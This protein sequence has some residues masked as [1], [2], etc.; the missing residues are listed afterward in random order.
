MTEKT[1]KNFK[2]LNVQ[3]QLLFLLTV[4]ADDKGEVR[5]NKEEL[6]KYLDVSRQTVGVHLK[7]FATCNLLKYKYSGIAKLN[8]E[9][10]Y[11]GT[12]VNLSSAIEDYSKFTTDI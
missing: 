11:N 8:P 9:F 2:K 4:C 3:T 12:A 10:F 7:T 6:A 5:L 1:I